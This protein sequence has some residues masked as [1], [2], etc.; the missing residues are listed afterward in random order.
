MYRVPRLFPTSTIVCAATGPSLTAEDIEA[1]KGVPLI[2]VNDAYRLAP[3]A[4]VLYA[5]DGKWWRHHQGVPEFAGLK[6]GLD[7]G[8]RRAMAGLGDVNLLRHTGT[9]GLELD[10]TALRT[11]KNS[12]YQAINLAVHLGAV[13]ILLVGY[14]LQRTGGQS[15]FFG[16]HPK[17]LRSETPFA[18]F[19]RHFATI[20]QPLKAIGVTVINCSRQTALTC[21]P[22]QSL[23]EAL[24]TGVAA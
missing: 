12:G 13:R 7:A 9:D 11:G 18:L 20:V 10:P 14:D 2:A 16:D 21:F 8:N 17:P 15:H 22:R 23:A 5:C 3:H 4:D 6:I 19:V 1:C 24:E